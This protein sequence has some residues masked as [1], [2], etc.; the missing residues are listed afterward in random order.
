MDEFDTSLERPA[1]YA[2]QELFSAAQ[3]EELDKERSEL[4]RDRRAERGTE[5]DVAC[6][7][8]VVGWFN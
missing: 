3:R 7:D 1:K 8:S 2:D 5:A 4:G 6:T